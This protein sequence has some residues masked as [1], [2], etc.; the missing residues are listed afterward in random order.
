MVDQRVLVMVLSEALP[1]SGLPQ[2]GTARSTHR[3]EKTNCFRSGRLS[4]LEP[5]VIVKGIAG[6][7]WSGG[8]SSGR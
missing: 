3:V 2:R 1:S 8:P 4:V 7:G 6:A 5:W